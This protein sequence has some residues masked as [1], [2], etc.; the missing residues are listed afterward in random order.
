MKPPAFDYHAPRTDEEA[1]DLL[2]RFGGEAKILAGGQSLIPAMNFRLARPAVLIDLNG[3]GDLAYVVEEASGGVRIGSMTRQRTV[4]TSSLVRDCSPLLHAAMPWV[5][6]VQIRNRG[7]LGGSLAHADPAAELPAVMLAMRARFR[8][9]NNEDER[10]L[11]ARDF[12]TGFFA[13]ALAED[14]MLCEIVVPCLPSYSGTAFREFARRHGDYA[15][16]GCCAVL[17]L[18]EG[19][20][21]SSAD[22]T[23]KDARLTYFSVADGPVEAVQAQSLL[24]GQSPAEGLFAEAAYTA[25]QTDLDP[26][27]DIHASPAFRR[28]L[29][30]VLTGQALAEALKKALEAKD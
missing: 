22:Q 1:L 25:A 8:L 28:Q 26:P 29:V 18:E 3:I 15:L 23:I 9:E 12:F 2:S 14:E 7:T 16:A 30:E 5:A 19:Q 24:L 27:G 13:T 21:D 10:W 11:E 6:H 4:E 17:T 20:G